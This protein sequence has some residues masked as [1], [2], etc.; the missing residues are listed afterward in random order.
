V[1]AMEDERLNCKVFFHDHCFDGACSA[2][3]FTRFHRECVGTV[4]EFA[5]QG[6]VHRAGSLFDEG[7]WGA[8]ENAIVDFKYS[9]SPKLTWWF[10]HHQSA[11]A[12]AEEEG[13]FRAGVAD[14]S[15]AMRQFFDPNYTSCAGWIADVASTKFGMDVRP[16][17]ELIYWANIVDGAKYESAQAAVEMHEPAMKLTMVIESAPDVNGVSI[18][19][20]FI[21][22]L[23]EMPLQQV[24]AQ[25]FV[26][27]VLGPLMERHWAGLELIK[28]RGVCERGVITFDITDQPT[29]GYSKFIPYYVWPEG[30]YT[31][32]LSKSSF[33]TKISVGTNPWTKRPAAELANIAEICERYGGGGHARVGA[34]S[35]PVDQEDEARAAVKVIVEE[36][37][38]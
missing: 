31:V 38:G 13:K 34:I 20:R 9:S 12:S 19:A 30:T 6:L 5:Y 4:K 32:G 7:W 26:Q 2:A 24:L 18:S 27:E 14:G 17:K 33:R 15:L 11:F 21:P 28:K 23:T 37:R 1:H 29:E 36:L 22:L 25:P 16:L 8:G 35:F 3:M 10:D